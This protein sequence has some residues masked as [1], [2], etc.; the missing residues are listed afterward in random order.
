MTTAIHR[1]DFSPAPDPFY[2]HVEL[3]HVMELPVFGI[4]TV[5]STNSAYVRDLIDET[6][7]AWR[8]LP[9]SEQGDERVSVSLVV[10]EGEESA[11]PAPLTFRLPDDD[12]M[13]VHSTGSVGTADPMR[14]L[15]VAYVTPALA[16]QREHFRYGIIESLT[17]V[18]LTPLDRQPVHAA[19]LTRGGPARLLAAPSG[20]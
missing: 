18:L 10:H 5:F 3:P 17:F 4:R 15:A 20:T 8:A 6:F 1:V 7:G 14:R 16:A 9:A 2:R 19:A 12:R 11:D 13:L